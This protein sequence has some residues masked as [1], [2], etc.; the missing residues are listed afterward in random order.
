MEQFNEHS[1]K[2]PLVVREYLD[3][4]DDEN[5]SNTFTYNLNSS[6]LIKFTKF[7]EVCCQRMV[8]EDKFDSICEDCRYGKFQIPNYFM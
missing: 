7:C 3:L 2:L 6:R 4:F 8:S 5:V 1:E